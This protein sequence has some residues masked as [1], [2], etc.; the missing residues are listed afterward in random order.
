MENDI[1]LIC[2]EK[3]YCIPLSSPKEKLKNMKN[4]VD[5]HRILDVDAE[6]I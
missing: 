3:Q 6:R 2:G 1:V 5:F 4:G